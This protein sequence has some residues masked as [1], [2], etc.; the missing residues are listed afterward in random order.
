MDETNHVDRGQEPQAAVPEA[1]LVP[2]ADEWAAGVHP[3]AVSAPSRR[4]RW[5]VAGAIV[6]IVALATTAGAFVLSGAA[7]AKSLTAGVAPRNS[8]FFMEVR[9]DLPGDQRTKLAGFMSHFPGFQDRAQFDNGLDE[10]L[11]MLTGKVSPDLRYTSAFKPWAEG[12]ISIAIGDLGSVDSSGASACATP[13]IDPS[14]GVSGG[15]KGVLGGVSFTRAPNAVA[16]F[17]LKDRAGAETWITGELSR[18]K[19]TT[20]SQDYAGSKLYTVGTGV[21]QGAYALTDQD[22]LLGTV[23]G[24]KA[25]LDTRTGG[26]LADNPDYQAAMKSLSGDSLARFYVDGRAIGRQALDSYE[27]V[28]CGVMGVTGATRPAFDPAAL[29][30]WI[31]G[32]VRAESDRIVVDVAMPQTATT[33]LGNHVS[34]IASSLPGNTV[35]VV[36]VH[37]LGRAVD[38]GIAALESMAPVPGLDA[39]SIDGVKSAL[40]LVGGV[41]WIGDGAAVVTQ[42]GSTFDGGV[43][44]EATDAATARSKVA[45]IGSL[46]GLSGVATGLKTHAETYK[47]QT[48]TVVS[49]PAGTSN[50]PLQLAIAA[51]D[52]LIVVGY[53]DAFVKGVLDTTPASS[54]ASQADYSTAIGASGAAN[55]ASVYANV[56][57]LEGQ[58]GTV[59]FSGENSIDYKPYLDH[60]GGIAGSVTDGNPVILRF[61]V[62]A[63]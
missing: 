33:N 57:A 44:V 36:E 47:G 54:L 32:A 20:T 50:G 9:T 43:V 24:V 34:R 46:V 41:G 2:M 10:L 27:P 17:A 21:M 18:Q 38:T 5:A 58:I 45:M 35:G 16:I 59:A 3:V 39:G 1:S 7:G 37:S 23:M 19:L 12:E 62:T 13:S 29:P 53:T 22:L 40:S 31:A 8:I 25:A 55:E 49:V 52:N 48:I 42:D 4:F 11:N 61:V 51:K 63:R 56:P 28:M 60:V 14:Q 30:A 15:L 6:V 26:S